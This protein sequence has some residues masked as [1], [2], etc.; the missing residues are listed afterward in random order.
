MEPLAL[1]ITAETLAT[2]A[3]MGLGFLAA[4]FLGA[5]FLPGIERTGYPQPDGTRKRYSLTG[6]TLF[7]LSHV[8]VGVAVIGFGV[9]LTPIAQHFWPLLVVALAT[10]SAIS[11][12]LCAAAHRAGAAAPGVERE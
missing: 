4:M 11:L 3:K 9:S 12:A 2:A 7:F 1:P 5:R 8:V 6:M 10:A